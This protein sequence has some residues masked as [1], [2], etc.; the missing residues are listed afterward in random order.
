M[1][2]VRF[3]AP[4]KLRDKKGKLCF[5]AYFLGLFALTVFPIKSMVF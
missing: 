5:D 2:F 1:V 4:L 3:R